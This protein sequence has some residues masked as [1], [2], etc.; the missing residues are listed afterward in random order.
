MR[1]PLVPRAGTFSVTNVGR[2][3]SDQFGRFAAPWSMLM[4]M[5]RLAPSLSCKSCG[6][7]VGLCTQMQLLTLD[8]SILEYIVATSWYCT[9]P[10]VEWHL[11]L[12]KAFR[13]LAFDLGAWLGQPVVV[14][15]PPLFQ[16][17]LV[18]VGPVGDPMG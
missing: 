17:R 14:I 15:A 9:R 16:P 8:G 7:T 5:A 18:A 3:S 6:M 10:P 11:V 1:S 13:H 12:G 2:P 4:K